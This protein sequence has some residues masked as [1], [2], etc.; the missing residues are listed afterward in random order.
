[1]VSQFNSQKEI[2]TGIATTQKIQAKTVNQMY[3]LSG[4]QQEQR[5]FY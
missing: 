2:I 1:M 3:N 5:L 4:E